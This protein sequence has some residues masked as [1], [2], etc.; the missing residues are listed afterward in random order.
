MKNLLKEKI[1]RGE[2]TLGTFF[3]LGSATAAVRFWYSPA[4][5]PES[6]MQSATAARPAKPLQVRA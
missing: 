2:K 6:A 5:T 1:L 4:N 3:E